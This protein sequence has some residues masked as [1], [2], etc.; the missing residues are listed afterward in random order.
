MFVGEVAHGSLPTELALLGIVP[1][2]PANLETV[3]QAIFL[4][5]CRAT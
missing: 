3:R 1:L 5:H 2:L 4:S